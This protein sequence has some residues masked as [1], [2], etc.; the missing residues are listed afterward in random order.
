MTTRP[1]EDDLDLHGP[2]KRYVLCTPHTCP[3]EECGWLLL[4]SPPQPENRKVLSTD[5]LGVSEHGRRPNGHLLP[6]HSGPNDPEKNGHCITST[7]VTSSGNCYP[8]KGRTSNEHKSRP[9]GRRNFVYKATPLLCRGVKPSRESLDESTETS[10]TR[11]S[12]DLNT[13]LTKS[14]SRTDPLLDKVAGNQPLAN[15]PADGPPPAYDPPQVVNDP[16]P[17]VEGT[18]NPPGEV[19]DRGYDS[20]SSSPERR[21]PRTSTP[22]PA[23]HEPRATCPLYY[24]PLLDDTPVSTQHFFSAVESDYEIQELKVT[25]SKASLI[26]DGALIKI[27]IEDRKALEFLFGHTVI[28]KKFVLV[29][30]IDMANTIEGTAHLCWATTPL[31]PLIITPL[32]TDTPLDKAANIL[33]DRGDRPAWGPVTNMKRLDPPKAYQGRV[34]SAWKRNQILRNSFL[35]KPIARITPVVP[36]NYKDTTALVLYLKPPTVATTEDVKNFLITNAG[37]LPRPAVVVQFYD[38][39]NEVE[40]MKWFLGFDND[41]RAS[42]FKEDKE[43]IKRLN[44]STGTTWAIGQC[45][46]DPNTNKPATP[47][48][49]P[50]PRGKGKGKERGRGQRGRGKGK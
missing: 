32:H 39:K 40:L 4:G 16:P 28:G 3:K 1:R 44:H 15:L 46:Q 45:G 2:N 43:W 41:E 7:E 24:A 11:H 17:A 25:W 35:T 30:N 10:L 29:S 13:V 42:T 19:E 31:A 50:K 26:F 21:P 5:S 22:T 8:P 18:N 33:W 12:P 9:T 37:H 14:R 23:R 47:T 34:W 36:E 48:I 20:W 27:I 6:G 49:Q 38:Y